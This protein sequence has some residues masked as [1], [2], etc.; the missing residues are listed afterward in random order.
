M[1]DIHKHPLKPGREMRSR[2]QQF[3]TQSARFESIPMKVCI[4]YPPDTSPCRQYASALSPRGDFETASKLFGKWN[5]PSAQGS[6]EPMV[7]EWS[8]KTWT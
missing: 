2:A 5:F 4:F 1:N 8:M 6:P 7:D 3:H